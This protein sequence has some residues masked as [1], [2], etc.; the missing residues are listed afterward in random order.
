APLSGHPLINHVTFTGS[1]GTGIAV[2]QAAMANVVPSTLE[3]GGKSPNIVFA[4]C[5][6]DKTVAG[7]V[8]SIIQTAGQPCSAGARLLVEESFKEAFRQKGS[9]KFENRSVGGGLDDKDIG[10]I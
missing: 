4:D 10:A 7:V 9:E 5:D 2:G 6:V 1:V 8:Q 3:L